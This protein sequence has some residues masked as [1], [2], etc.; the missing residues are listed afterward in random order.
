M[1]YIAEVVNGQF[2]DDFTA[3]LVVPARAD[4]D[5]RCIADGNNTAFGAT[6]QIVL[7]DN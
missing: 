6:Y 7:I 3:P 4:I 5:I 2:R 1:V